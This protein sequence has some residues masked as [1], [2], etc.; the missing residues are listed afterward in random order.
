MLRRSTSERA[1][2]RVLVHRKKTLQNEKDPVNAN[3]EGVLTS[4]PPANLALFLSE[5]QPVK[6][7]LHHEAPY[8]AQRGRGF[9]ACTRAWP[10]WCARN[11]LQFA[12]ERPAPRLHGTLRPVC[13]RR[14]SPPAV[15]VQV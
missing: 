14:C 5:L 13:R 6:L 7:E 2:R 10:R 8:C 1:L 3:H 12:L 9:C 15:P 11:T 4:V